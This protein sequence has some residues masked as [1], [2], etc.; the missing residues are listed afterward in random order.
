[1]TV[2]VL[3]LVVGVVLPLLVGI[4]TKQSTDP[5]V[6]AVLLALLSAVSGFLAEYL[7]AL[8]TAQNF[9]WGTVAMTFLGTFLVAVG[10]HYGLWKPTGVADAAQ[11]S[12]V[13]DKPESVRSVRPTA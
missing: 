8:N 12:V 10:M 7:T 4:V 6:K 11:S 9:D 13:T 5:G 1:M 3:S 2:Q